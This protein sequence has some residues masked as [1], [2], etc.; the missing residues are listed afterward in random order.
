MCCTCSCKEPV[1][2]L[3]LSHELP[4]IISPYDGLFIENLLLC[5]PLA[6]ALTT[7]PQPLRGVLLGWSPPSVFI[8][9]RTKYPRAASQKMSRLPNRKHSSWPQR[10]LEHPLWWNICFRTSVPSLLFP[11]H[12]SLNYQWSFLYCP[13]LWRLASQQRNLYRKPSKKKHV[14]CIW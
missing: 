13:L 1:C 7:L 10:Y 11:H 12:F 6:C 3:L 5:P 14:Q 4:T 2:V 9:A 8:T